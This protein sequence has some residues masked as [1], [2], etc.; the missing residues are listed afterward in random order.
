MLGDLGTRLVYSAGDVLVREGAPATSLYV[1]RRGTVRLER[2]G[3][4]DEAALAWLGPADVVGEGAVLGAAEA[5]LT[6]VAES[7][8][9][10]DVLDTRVLGEVVATRPG[11]AARFFR[12]VAHALHER[13]GSVAR[14]E[15]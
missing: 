1:L 5:A 2:R 13:L 7:E 9:H 6:A 14:R 3:R 11:F 8:V 12:G 4:Q 15:A 10:V